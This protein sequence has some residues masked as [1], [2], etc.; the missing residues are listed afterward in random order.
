M[1]SIALLFVMAA[2]LGAQTPGLPKD[3]DP[4]SF[5]RLPLLTR[6]DMKDEDG[7][8]I[9][10]RWLVAPARPWV[11]PDQRPSRSTAPKSPKPSRC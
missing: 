2:A 7:K 9:T 10:T 3:I 8:R 1:R 4:Q 11:Q 6:D 5:S